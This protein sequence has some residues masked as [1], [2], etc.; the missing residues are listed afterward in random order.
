MDNLKNLCTN[1]S[2]QNLKLENI[3][4]QNQT[5]FNNLSNQLKNAVQDILNFKNDIDK[6]IQQIEM[7]IERNQNLLAK[8]VSGANTKLMQEQIAHKRAALTNQVQKIN[9]V[10]TQISQEIDKT[11]NDFGTSSQQIVADFKN[12]ENKLQNITKTN[13]TVGASPSIDVNTHLQ[14]SLKQAIDALNSARQGIEQ[15]KVFNEIN[16]SIDNLLQ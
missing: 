2:D 5:S 11:L 8:W 6:T 1:F 16:K 9:D 12:T 7:E 15:Q 14:Q 3:I 13:Q 10:F 4:T